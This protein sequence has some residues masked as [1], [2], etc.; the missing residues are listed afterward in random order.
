MI[1]CQCDIILMKINK[2]IHYFLINYNSL[3]NI[4]LE[5][6]R[7]ASFHSELWIE[8]NDKLKIIHKFGC[9]SIY[10][11]LNHNMTSHGYMIGQIFRYYYL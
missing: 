2:K 10:S 8:S 1:E 5:I 11:C 3:P 4:V 7:I 6:F 9:F